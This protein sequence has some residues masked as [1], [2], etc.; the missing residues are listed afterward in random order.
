MSQGLYLHYSNI[1][2]S[3]LSNKDVLKS[4]GWSYVERNARFIQIFSLS[5]RNFEVPSQYL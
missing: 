2:L 5:T 4:E 3:F 1:G